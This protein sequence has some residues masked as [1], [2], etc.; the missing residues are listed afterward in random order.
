MSKRHPSE[1]QTPEIVIPAPSVIPAK[2]GI[3]AGWSGETPL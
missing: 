3:Q 2:A 1:A